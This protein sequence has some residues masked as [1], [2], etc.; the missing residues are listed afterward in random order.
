MIP[1][2]SGSKPLSAKPKPILHVQL[3]SK[4]IE[5]L[6][7]E[8]C[9]KSKTVKEERDIMQQMARVERWV[10]GYTNF[11]ELKLL[12]WYD[13]SACPKKYLDFRSKE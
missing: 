6:L 4:S 7:K 13:F 12:Q 1:Q 11:E 5:T 10:N 9:T 8:A 2:P 3:C